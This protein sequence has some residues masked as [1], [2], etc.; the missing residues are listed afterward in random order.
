MPHERGAE[1]NGKNDPPNADK[2]VDKDKARISPAADNTRYDGHF[3]SR[4]EARD[5]QNQN[6]LLRHFF[7]RGRKIIQ[8]KDRKTKKEKQNARRKA[9]GEEH[10]L[11]GVDISFELLQLPFSDR[12][13]DDNG[14]RRSGAHRR[15]F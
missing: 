8:R 15:D 1:R 3:I 2:V 10:K 12:L 5:A 4:A 14:G 9:D 13:S 6:E 7:G 11:Q